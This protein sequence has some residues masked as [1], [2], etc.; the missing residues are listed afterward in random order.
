MT[1]KTSDPFYMRPQQ[2][3]QGFEI[4]ARNRQVTFFQGSLEVSGRDQG[5]PS[6]SIISRMRSIHQLQKDVVPFD[7]SPNFYSFK[8][9]RN[10]FRQPM[11]PGQSVRQT[12]LSY[13]PAARLGID[14]RAPKK[15]YKF[16]LCTSSRLPVRVS[17][18]SPSHHGVSHFHSY[19]KLGFLL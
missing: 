12:G 6:I 3:S 14:S 18:L 17:F 15:V 9:P 13:R 19:P 10:L 16:G 5:C 7:Q 2:Y 11:Q 4:C 8:D 1:E